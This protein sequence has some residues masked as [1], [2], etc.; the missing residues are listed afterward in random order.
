[1]RTTFVILAAVMIAIGS[2]VALVGVIAVLDP[3][4]TKAA[5]DSDPFGAQPPR[6]ESAAFTV[7]GLLLIGGGVFFAAKSRTRQRGAA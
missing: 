2:V 6:W 1:M 4:G 5:D 3:V 7:A